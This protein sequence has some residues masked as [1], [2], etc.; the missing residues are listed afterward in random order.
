M[1]ICVSYFGYFAHIKIYSCS[2]AIPQKQCPW[3]VTNFRCVTSEVFCVVPRFPNYWENPEANWFRLVS[4]NPSLLQLGFLCEQWAFHLPSVDVL[5]SKKYCILCHP[6][7]GNI[8]SSS[9]LGGQKYGGI[10]ASRGRRRTQM[11]LCWV[12]ST[13]ER[14]HQCVSPIF[15]QIVISHRSKLTSVEY[16]SQ[17]KGHLRPNIR[18]ETGGLCGILKIRLKF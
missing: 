2:F 15:L 3:N 18:L 5:L 13:N 8:F 9:L 17:K 7:L 11:G 1:M 16:T 10:T 14:R 12:P 6:C 4:E